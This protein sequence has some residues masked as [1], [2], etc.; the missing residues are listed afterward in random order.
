MHGVTLSADPSKIAL[1][2]E[3]QKMINIIH[4]ELLK[5]QE[6]GDIEKITHTLVIIEAAKRKLEELAHSDDMSQTNQQRENKIMRIYWSQGPRE[7]SDLDKSQK[8]VLLSAG[9]I[10]GTVILIPLLVMEWKFMF[11]FLGMNISK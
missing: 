5:A 11:D 6:E 7:Y 4:L 9:I 10:A 1:R 3:L 8:I 2:L